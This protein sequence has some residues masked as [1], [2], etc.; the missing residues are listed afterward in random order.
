MRDY[1]R[2]APTFWTKGSGKRL[3]GKPDAQLLGLYLLT[4]SSA[5]ML[6]LYYLPLVT[7]CHETGLTAAEA[8]S[9]LAVTSDAGFAHYDEEAEL[10]WLPNGAAYQIGEGLALGDKRRMGLVRAVK[11][12]LGHRFAVAFFE[13]YAEPYH[14]EVPDGLIRGPLVAIRGF[15]PPNKGSETPNKDSEMPNKGSET[16]NKE[17]GAPNKELARPL[18]GASSALNAPFSTLEGAQNQEQEQKQKQ[19]QE[20]SPR[21]ALPDGCAEVFEH[22]LIAEKRHR[23]TARRKELPDQDRKLLRAKLKSGMTVDDLKLA[24]DGLFLSPHHTGKNDQGTEY[25]AF[26]YVMKGNNA[27]TFIALARQRARER[28]REIPDADLPPEKLV[29]SQKLLELGEQLAKIGVA[30]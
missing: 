29:S 13:K 24:C 8:R 11:P 12:Y 5:N 7:L 27:D 10:V 30:S 16:T 18:G 25:L 22:F 28:E 19:E 17:I 4:C 23:P 15:G 2:V 26:H 3:R 14:L 1:A 21:P 9:A 20:Q 6:G